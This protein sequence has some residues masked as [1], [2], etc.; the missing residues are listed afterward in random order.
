MCGLTS[1]LAMR[2]SLVMFQG[3]IRQKVLGVYVQI[4]V[5]GSG[6]FVAPNDPADKYTATAYMYI[7]DRLC[8]TYMVAP[9]RQCKSEAGNQYPALFSLDFPRSFAPEPSRPTY[10]S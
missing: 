5:V 6:T 10:A 1:I 9:T 7:V 8:A 3:L 4:Y 2:L